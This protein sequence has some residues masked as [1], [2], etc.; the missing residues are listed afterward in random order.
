[1]PIQAAFTDLV[2]DTLYVVAGPTVVDY[3]AGAG[4][5]AVWRSRRHVMDNYQGYGWARVNGPALT[6]VVL[7]LYGDGT[8]FYT[9]PSIT[10]RSP[11]RLP[12]GQFKR[13]E[14]EVETSD[15]ITSVVIATTTAELE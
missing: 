2:T 10:S 7:R 9:T 3:H 15:R 6:G 5:V 11:V 12:A 14:L 8:L 4:Q 13:W 1:M